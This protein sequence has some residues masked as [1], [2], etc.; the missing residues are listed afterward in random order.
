MTDHF[1]SKNSENDNFN[2]QS[3]EGDYQDLMLIL[4]EIKLNIAS[5]EKQYLD[6]L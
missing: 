4:K 1:T 5:L 2:L 6:K 3:E